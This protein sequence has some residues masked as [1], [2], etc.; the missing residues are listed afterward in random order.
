ML[1]RSR[2]AGILTSTLARV[3]PVEYVMAPMARPQN[4]ARASQMR[5]LLGVALW[6]QRSDVRQPWP[7][8]FA[9]ERERRFTP[10]IPPG[11]TRR[12]GTG[13]Y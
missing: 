12:N 2:V 8:A 3:V 6:S 9:G 7:S 10:A 13:V 5:A 1:T 11:S 4:F